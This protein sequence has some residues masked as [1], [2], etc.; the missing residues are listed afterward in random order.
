[1]NLDELVASVPEEELRE[2]LSY[3]VKAWKQD[4]SDIKNLACVIGK[5]HGNVWFKSINESNGF[6]ERFQAFKSVAIEGNGG[7]TLNEKIYYFGL[8]E[9]WDRSNEAG[10]LRIRAKLYASKVEPCQLF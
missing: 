7:F 9:E 2:G 5:W 3:W 1:M 8:F 4:E 10:Q 6:N